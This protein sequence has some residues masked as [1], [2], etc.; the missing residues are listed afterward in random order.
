LPGSLE[1]VGAGLF[2]SVLG[3]ELVMS[4]LFV[5]F[6]SLMF[7][8]MAWDS[9]GLSLLGGGARW[10]ALRWGALL[11]T[12][13]AV[14]PWRIL[15]AT[16]VHFGALHLLFNMM[17]V[18]DLG[19]SLERQFGSARFVFVLLASAVAGFLVSQVWYLYVAQTNALTGGASGGLFGLAGSLIGALYA[20]RDPAWKP[21]AIRLLIY[22]ALFAVMLP[23]NNAAHAG[24]FLLG[25]PC[26]Y[27]FA[28]ER[29]PWHRNRLFSI[30]AVLGAVASVASVILSHQSDTW[31]IVREMEEQRR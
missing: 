22:S 18:F 1:R 9:G 8:F 29:R 3:R 21:V 11:P 16:F 12:L 5:G 4:K 31:R 25:L 20:R 23:V 28:K 10:S 6:C 19:Q 30:L 13:G 2:E 17:A 7:V 24:G 14:E 15:S 26:G 27:A